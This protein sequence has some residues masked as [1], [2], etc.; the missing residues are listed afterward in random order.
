MDVMCGATAL[1]L[2]TIGRQWLE[3]GAR[4]DVLVDLIEDAPISPCC[5]S[6]KK[7]DL[8]IYSYMKFKRNEP[9]LLVSYRS[10]FFPPALCLGFG[11]HE[12]RVH[13]GVP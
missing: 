9:S 8:V 2:D 10:S 6:Y 1:G 7:L 3:E 5:V 12:C 11:K 13:E 4:L